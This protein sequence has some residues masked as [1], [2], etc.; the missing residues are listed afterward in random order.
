MGPV[1]QVHCAEQPKKVVGLSC[2]RRLEGTR[3]ALE[4]L[5]SRLRLEG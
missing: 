2:I 3:Q 5:R 4:G 1:D